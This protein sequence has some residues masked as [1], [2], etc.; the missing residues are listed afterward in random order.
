LDAL[1]HEGGA[2]VAGAHVG[3][4]AEEDRG[5]TVGADHAVFD[6]RLGRHLI[7]KR[8]SQMEKTTVG[9]RRESS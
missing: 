8:I 7:L 4:R 2:A 5:R 6:L 9:L 3:A 1:L